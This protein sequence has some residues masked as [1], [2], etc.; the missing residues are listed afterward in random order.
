MR[1]EL[2]IQGTSGVDGRDAWIREG[3][4]YCR[5][6]QRWPGSTEVV[7]TFVTSLGMVALSSV[8]RD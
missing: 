5:D 2:G 4:M 8:V 6:Y 7:I 3:D 1:Q